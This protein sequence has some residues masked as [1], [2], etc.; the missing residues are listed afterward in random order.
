MAA[1][2]EEDAV[3]ADGAEAARVVRAACRRA[4]RRV[5]DRD[6]EAEGVIL[7]AQNNET[8]KEKKRKRYIETS[9][10]TVVMSYYI[11][12]SLSLSPSLP[13]NLTCIRCKCCVFR[14]AIYEEIALHQ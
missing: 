11:W 6:A 14:K 7:P 9:K 1:A 13:Y 10:K 12:L 8:T 4:P 3:E 5:M 2:E